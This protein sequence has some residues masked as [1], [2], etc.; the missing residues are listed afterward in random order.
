MK[1]KGNRFETIWIHPHNPGI[2]QIIDQRFIPFDFRIEDLCTDEEI[3]EAIRE[4]HLRGA[5][6]IGA[7]GAL[8]MYLAVFHYYDKNVPP[9]FIREK[10]AFLKSARPTAVNLAWAIDRISNAL[11]KGGKKDEIIALARRICQDILNEER[12][13]CLNIGR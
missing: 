7:A 1:V 9:Q 6:L 11:E 3:F 2:V 4:M 10:A 5:P 8:G 12:E 13:N